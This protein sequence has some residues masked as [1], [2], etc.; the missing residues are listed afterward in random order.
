VIEAACNGHG[1]A[2]VD[3]FMVSSQLHSGQ[4]VPVLDVEIEGHESYWLVTRTDQPEAA[5]VQHF[6]SLAS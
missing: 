4:L 5:N 2:V 3:R 1:I 6:R